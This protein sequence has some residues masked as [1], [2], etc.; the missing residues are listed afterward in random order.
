MSDDEQRISRLACIAA[1]RR[2]AED[3]R[4]I[5]TLA[6]RLQVGADRREAQRERMDRAALDRPRNA[7]DKRLDDAVAHGDLQRLA[8]MAEQGIIEPNDARLA[9]DI[10]RYDHPE[11]RTRSVWMADRALTAARFPHRM[12]DI[13]GEA[14]FTRTVEARTA[15][16]EVRHRILGAVM[17][18]LWD[19]A[20]QGLLDDDARWGADPEQDATDAARHLQIPRQEPEPDRPIERLAQRVRM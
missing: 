11:H 7:T 20:L 14:R 9:A 15:N 10:V 12:E 1:E 2:A 8:A 16:P 17:D 4:N 3:A 18:K 5:P 6:E 19:G 13:A